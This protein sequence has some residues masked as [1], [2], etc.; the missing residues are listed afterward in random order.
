MRLHNQKFKYLRLKIIKYKI[1]PLKKLKNMHKIKIKPLK[2]LK[3]T[4][5]IKP[6]R[7]RRVKIKIRIRRKANK[8][9]ITKLKQIKKK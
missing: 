6:K 9:R 8:L 1:K 7:K 2:R 5:K 4:H 3:D